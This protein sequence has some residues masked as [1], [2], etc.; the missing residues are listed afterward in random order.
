MKNRLKRFFLSMFSD[1]YVA[2]STIRHRQ[3]AYHEHACRDFAVLSARLSGGITCFG[4]DYNG[5]AVPRIATA[6]A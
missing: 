3:S 2:E 5:A 4:A 1:K 6:R